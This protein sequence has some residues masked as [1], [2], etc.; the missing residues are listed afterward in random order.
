MTTPTRRPDASM[1]LL[2]EMMQR[3][4]DPGYAAAADRREAAGLP[5]STGVRGPTL[6]IAAVLVG[7]LV[8]VAALALRPAGTTA[9]RE[10][11]RL[12]EQIQ[13][14]KSHGDAL[15]QTASQLRGQIQGFRTAA[16]GSQ[17]AALTEQLA[18][19]G[20]L[21]G[22]T[23]AVGAGIV[24][25][26]DDAPTASQGD[27]G[28]DPRTSTGFSPG[29]VTSLD[30]QLL[31]NG[32]W[33][34]GA[35][36]MAING[37]RLTARSAIRFAGEAILVDYRP[38]TPPYVITAVGDPQGLQAGFAQTMAG[39]YLKALGDNYKIPSTIAAQDRVEV[40]G[41]ASLDLTFARPPAPG[42]PSS[43]GPPAGAPAPIPKATP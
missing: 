43:T 14:R 29:R 6:A 23:G 20:L 4:L 35:E 26:I 39:S 2:T 41:A 15:A 13:S 37:Q 27:A 34:A 18:R 28:V 11:A 31:T 21:A 12:V 5:R 7:F 9:S 33:Q 17:E 42:I 3:P 38:L 24:L 19:L 30:L 22:E 1:T 8:A 36:A 16:L 40:P 32:L 10:K 25:T